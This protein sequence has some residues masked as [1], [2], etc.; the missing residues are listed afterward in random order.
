MKVI[1]MIG[2]AVIASF[3]CAAIIL[4]ALD[5]MDATKSH[6]EVTY[7]DLDPCNCSYQDHDIDTLLDEYHSGSASWVGGEDGFFYD[8]C[9]RTVMY[10]NGSEWVERCIDCQR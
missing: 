8:C 1:G 3:L 7:T 9:N 5:H 2:I 4:T 10:N 6:D